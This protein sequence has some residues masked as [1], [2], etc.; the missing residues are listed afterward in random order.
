[1]CALV[2][3]KQAVPQ[4]TKSFVLGLSSIL[5]AGAAS[6]FAYTVSDTYARLSQVRNRA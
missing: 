2:W 5:I 6:A 1:M 4:A 3:A